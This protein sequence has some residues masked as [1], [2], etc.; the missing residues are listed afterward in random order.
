[1]IVR[2]NLRWDIIL[3]SSYKFII[4]SFCAAALAYFIRYVMLYEKA[5]IPLGVISTLGTA[6]AISVGFRNNVS[7]DRWW[8]ARIIWGGIVNNSRSFARQVLTLGTLQH[9]KE[10]VAEIDLKP[11]QR[12]LIYRHLA[13]INT[14]RLQLRKQE[15]WSDIQP[16]ISQTE[17]HY[18][19]QTKNKATQLIRIQAE[20]IR[21]A[22]LLGIFDGF[23][24]IQLDNTMNEFY[25]LQGAAERIKNTPL[26]RQYSY[27]T[28]VFIYIFTF[29]FPFSTLPDYISYGAPLWVFPLT[30]IIGW[31][32]FV[33][34]R[35]GV[36]NEDPF[37]NRITD[38]PMTALC[39]TIEI[40]LREMLGETDLPP[41]LEPVGGFLY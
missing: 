11:I 32:F 33:L 30:V 14:L 36:Y 34:H 17:F 31:V 27:F 4:Y 18:I 29:L 24:H 37:E 8:E 6:L 15:T 20:R 28:K 39:R 16:F 26:A 38:T 9:A 19:L 22:H 40:D 7:Y 13:W 5:Q 35:I 41:K 25:N 23:R 10:T 12:E 3:R 21:D 1:M 2:E